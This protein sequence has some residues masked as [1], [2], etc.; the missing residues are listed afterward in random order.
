MSDVSWPVLDP[1]ALHGLAGLVTKTVLPHT[2]ADEAGLLLN[3]LA[4]AGNY[5]GS[6]VHAIAEGAPHP[7]RLYVV[8]VGP[9]SRSRKG[10]ATSQNRRIWKVVDETYSQRQIVDGLSSGEGLLH[11]LRD[12]NIQAEDEG[13]ADKRLLVIEEEFARV[14]T[15]ASREGNTLSSVVRQLWDRGEAHT[16]TRNNPISASGAHL[17][18]I[19]HITEGELI[20]KM[21]ESDLNNG[22]AN[23]HLYCC[24]K[25][26]KYLPSGGNLKVDTIEELAK[27]IRAVAA[28]VKGFERPLQLVRT[29]DAD[30]LWREMYEN[31]SDHPGLAGAVTARPEAQTLRL[32]VVYAL[33]DAKPEINVDHLEAAKAVWDFCEASALWIFGDMFEDNIENRLLEALRKAGETGLTVS[34]QGDLFNRHVSSARLDIARTSL[35]QR[36]LIKTIEEDTAGRRARRSIACEISE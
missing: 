35:Q 14:L 15:V 13:V 18:I 26:S 8:L 21:S 29:D 4:T 16:L 12:P 23:R 27:R 22:L 6:G 31:F 2:E 19:G 33:L 20:R 10:S 9:T 30:M 17:S 7:A 36:N 24:V 11:A 28:T 5:F 34:E 32:S 3:F 1:K 25:R